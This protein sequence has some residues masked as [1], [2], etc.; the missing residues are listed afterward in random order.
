MILAVLLALGAVPTPAA[1]SARS[2]GRSTCEVRA[3]TLFGDRAVL[4]RADSTDASLPAVSKR[5]ALELPDR[6]PAACRGTVVMHDVLIDPRGQVR[7]VFTRRAPCREFDRVARRSL[8]RW[9][10]EPARRGNEP[11]A[12]CVRVTTLFDRR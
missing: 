8:R 6:W 9:T 5:V 7:D 4:L 1:P 2:S 12:A 11:V 10:F 3:D